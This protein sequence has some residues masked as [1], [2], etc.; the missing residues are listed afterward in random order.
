M[1]ELRVTLS[2][3]RLTD[4]AVGTDGRNRTL[5][6]PFAS[7]T[8]RNQPSTS[9]F[10][11]G[12]SCWLRSLIRPGVEQSLAYIDWSGQ[13][14]GIAAKLS[15]DPM[16]MQDYQSGDP[17]L[18]F[19]KRIGFVPQDAIKHTHAREREMLK[20]ACGL[21]AMYGAGPDTL[22]S[23]LSVPRWQAQEWLR[24]HR[25]LY[26]TYWN[27][28]EAV[29]NTAMLT[30]HLHT[31]FGWTLHVGPHTSPRTFRNFP[32]QANGAELMR[33]AC[34]LATERDVLV[35]CPV[36]DALLI[37][38][39]T[40]EIDEAVATTQAAMNEASSIVLDGFVLRTDVK[41][42]QYPDRYGDKRGE[43]MWARIID[44]LAEAPG[45]RTSAPFGCAP[46]P[47]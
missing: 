33:L 20:V 1:R 19:G 41:R 46:V 26:A 12:P 31:V 3:M 16:M 37:E 18:A 15:A 40:V 21:G 23:T 4:L 38:A 36:H 43:K 8:S 22:A 5:L 28:S 13:E 39:P 47:L 30:N 25:E 9:K 11:F 45:Q 34:C 29:L 17:Y 42:V 24:Q 6:S 44:L 32:M 7:K 27:W 2:Q 10:I 35:C 14:Y